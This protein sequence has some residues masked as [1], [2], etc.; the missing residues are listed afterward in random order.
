MPNGWVREWLYTSTVA[1][2]Q[3]LIEKN[4]L[5]RKQIDALTK[6]RDR[7]KKTLEEYNKKAWCQMCGRIL[8]TYKPQAP[9][10]ATNR[11]SGK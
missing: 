6:E 11:E 5:L 8:K 1:E 9:D 3:K 4:K 2:N 7:L 10:V